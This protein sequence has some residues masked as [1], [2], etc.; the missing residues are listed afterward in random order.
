MT[1]LKKALLRCLGYYVGGL[2]FGAFLAVIYAWATG[3][4]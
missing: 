1:P 3:V 2:L 4:I